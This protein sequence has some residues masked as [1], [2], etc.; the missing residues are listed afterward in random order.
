MMNDKKQKEKVQKK[1]GVIVPLTTRS[2][3]SAALVQNLYANKQSEKNNQTI[4]AHD[5]IQ[6]E[7]PAYNVEI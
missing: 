7:I 6:S 3:Q 2:T 5:G 4:S 1:L